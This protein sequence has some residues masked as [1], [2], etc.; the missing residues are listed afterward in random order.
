M[1]T[2]CFLAAAMLAAAPLAGCATTYDDP[3]D[4]YY[5][6]HYRAGNY[7]PYP[8]SRND[9]I[10][11][12][13]DNRYYCRRDDGTTG[14]IVGGIGGGVLGNRY[15]LPLYPALWFLAARPARALW[16]VAVALLAAG[17]AHTG[18]GTTAGRS[19]PAVAHPVAA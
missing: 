16:A 17:G 2:P 8:L 5:E 18:A 4:G 6:R 3:Y 19:A 15:F 9:R 10:Y 14:L 11:R 1:R 7:D 13:S 12:G